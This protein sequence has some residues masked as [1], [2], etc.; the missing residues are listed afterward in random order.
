MIRGYHEYGLIYVW[1]NPTV[2]E[3]L[4]CKHANTELLQVPQLVAISKF[5]KVTCNLFYTK[6]KILESKILTNRS[7]FLQICQSFIYTANISHSMVY[8]SS[9]F[10][11]IPT[12]AYP[13]S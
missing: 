5:I 2:S 13:Q 11:F 3:E 4:A 7:V 10:N 1:N 6:H 8:D 9:L 12:Y